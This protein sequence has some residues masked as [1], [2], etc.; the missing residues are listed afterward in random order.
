ME[1]RK[2]QWLKDNTAQ[3]ANGFRQEPLREEPG[4]GDGGIASNRDGDRCGPIKRS[5]TGVARPRGNEGICG[6]TRQDLRRRRNNATLQTRPTPLSKAILVQRLRNSSDKD[7]ITK[8]IA[9]FQAVLA[10]FRQMVA[11]LPKKELLFKK[12]PVDENQWLPVPGSDISE[13]EPK[14]IE[15][16]TIFLNEVNRPEYQVTKELQSAVKST[17]PLDSIVLTFEAKFEELQA[18]QRMKHM[19]GRNIQAH[20][21]QAEPSL[22]PS[23]LGKRRG[24]GFNNF[25]T[26]LEFEKEHAFTA[27]QSSG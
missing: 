19:V 4:I 20:M 11:N 24:H 3:T 17:T 15:L 21:A 2:K 27:A 8:H 7:G 6:C 25:D 13:Y 23:H 5:S 9:E 16:Y 12:D 1:Q 18:A 10:Y 22:A 14:D 26:P